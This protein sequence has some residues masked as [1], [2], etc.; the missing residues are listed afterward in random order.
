MKTKIIISALFVLF[1]IKTTIAQVT[2]LRTTS[3][4]AQIVQENNT[5]SEWSPAIEISELVVLD[6]SKK[7]ISIFTQETQVYDIIK[8][9][10]N[11][12]DENGGSIFSFRCIDQNG[13]SADVTLIK[14]LTEET[15][16][17]YLLIELKE[18]KLLYSL[19]DID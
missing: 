5:W 2:K 9:L 15:L 14:E 13:N 10:E 11:E 1:S 12:K 7:R 17:K 19:T 4:N 3:V 6:F 16:N 8:V 18:D